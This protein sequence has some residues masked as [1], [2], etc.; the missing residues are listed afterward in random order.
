MR[1]VL[2]KSESAASKS[3]GQTVSTLPYRGTSEAIAD[4]L[5]NDW[6][7]KLAKDL[8]PKDAGFAL[9]LLTG[10]EERTCYRYASGETKAA[11]IFSP[12]AAAHRS[13]LASPRPCNGRL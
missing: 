10:F 2:E 9:H 11:S 1:A 3:T 8:Y 5:A 7:V 12:R 6:F 13:R 4:H